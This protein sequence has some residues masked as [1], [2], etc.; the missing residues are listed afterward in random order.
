MQTLRCLRHAVVG[1][2]SSRLGFASRSIT[3]ATPPST[4][5]FI[6]T[7]GP[8][9][10]HTPPHLAPKTHELPENT[11]AGIRQLFAQLSKS[12]LLELSTLTVERPVAALP[13]PPL[14]RTLPKGRRKR[15]RTYSGEGLA[16]EP[17]GIWDWVVTAQVK[18]GTEN[19][20]SIEAVVRQVRKTLLSMDPPLPL[21]P[22]SK[23]R[24][25]N[26]WAMIDAG[27]F[28]VHI[29]SRDARRKYFERPA[30]EW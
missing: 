21:P 25:L 30:A 14:P 9:T 17:G 11:S 18:E 28:A 29:L 22:N 4:P 2:G 3:G 26:G 10:R 27:N 15:G 16:E 23:R 20:G 7:E 19:R 8:V 12:P 5:W 1:P 6:D 13:G 24:M